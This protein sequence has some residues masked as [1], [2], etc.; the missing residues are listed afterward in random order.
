[1]TCQGLRKDRDSKTLG[2]TLV[3]LK[4]YLDYEKNVSVDQ[5]NERMKRG[6]KWKPNI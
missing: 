6:E 2:G 3:S 1:M 4:G 5:R